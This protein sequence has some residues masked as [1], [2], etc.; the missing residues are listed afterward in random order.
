MES[1]NDVSKEEGKEFGQGEQVRE[2][3]K[4]GEEGKAAEEGEV[5]KEK[6]EYV[7]K[8]GKDGEEGENAADSVVESKMERATCYEYGVHHSGFPLK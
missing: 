3:W 2:E 1:T 5:G 4:T 7:G 6:A 8:E